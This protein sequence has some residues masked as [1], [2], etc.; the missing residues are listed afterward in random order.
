MSFGALPDGEVTWH[1]DDPIAVGLPAVRGVVDA[2]FT[3]VHEV[4]ARPVRFETEAFW[5]M[6]AEIV[7]LRAERSTAELAIDPVLT[8]VVVARLKDLFGLHG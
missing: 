1:V 8:S 5:G 7:V 2:T 4:W 3:D 6:D